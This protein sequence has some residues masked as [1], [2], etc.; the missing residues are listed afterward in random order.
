MT[1]ATPTDALAAPR[2]NPATLEPGESARLCYGARSCTLFEVERHEGD[3]NYTVTVIKDRKPRTRGADQYHVSWS[4]RSAGYGWKGWSCWRKSEDD[5][6]AFAAGKLALCR[7]WA[8][9]KEAA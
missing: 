8:A 6:I 7:S 4:I 3:A 2:R 1:R 5:A 9:R